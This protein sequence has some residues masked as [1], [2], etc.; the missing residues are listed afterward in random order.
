MSDNQHFDYVVIGAGSAGCAVAHRLS[1]HKDSSVLLIEAGG[2]DVRPEIHAVDVPSLVALWTADWHDELDWG[3]TTQPERYLNNR[4]IPI[5]RGKVLGGCGAVN[6]LMWVRGSRLDY[7]RWAEEG[8]KGWSFDDVLPYFVRAEDYV[9]P[10]T[11]MRGAGGPIGVHEHRN[12]T[13]V[14]SAFVDAVREMGYGE[15]R[16]YNGPEQIDFGF[17]YQTT[18]TATGERCSPATA[19][20]HPIANRGNLSIQVN[21]RATRLLMTGDRVTGVEY[22]V[23]GMVQTVEVGTEAVLCGGAFETPKLLMLSGIGPAATLR[24]HGIDCRQDLPEVGQNLQDHLFVPVCYQSKVDHPVAELISEAGLFTHSGVNDPNGPP[25]LQ[26]T[27]GTA[28]FLPP[29][30]PVELQAGPGFTFGPVLIQPH[31]RGSVTLADADP[32]TPAVVSAGYLSVEADAEVLVRGIEL[33]RDVAAT[34]S[35]DPFRGEELYPGPTRLREYVAANATTLWHPVGTCRMGVD[36][37]AVVDPELCVRG[38]R[39][40]R[41]ADASV[42]PSII[43]GNTNAPCVMIGEKAADLIHRQ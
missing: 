41:V 4:R 18:R 28:K 2:W 7:D 19:Y 3:Y 22:V 11:A 20:L 21:A 15:D 13:P 42:M 14:A 39:G 5:A 29:D 26:L 31:S 25:D 34:K 37:R 27:F 40:L 12:P 8:A 32:A 33:S 10:F 23:N 17:L 43:A 36:D 24:A 9:G 35:F 30:A 38:V 1:E 16:D 6:A